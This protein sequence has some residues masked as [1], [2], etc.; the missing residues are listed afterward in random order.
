[1][2]GEG[3]GREEGDGERGCTGRRIIHRA[4][5]LLDYEASIQPVTVFSLQK[6]IPLTN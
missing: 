3:M 2:E 5:I 4:S 1:M 6:I